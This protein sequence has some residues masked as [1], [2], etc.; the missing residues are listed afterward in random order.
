M[1]KNS[2]MVI[3]EIQSC[4][5]SHIFIDEFHHL[6]PKSS[7]LRENHDMSKDG[8]QNMHKITFIMKECEPKARCLR[9][10]VHAK[11]RWL[12]WEMDLAS[13]VRPIA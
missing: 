4:M 6:L 2:R 3:W 12:R 11:G 1:I 8:C 5:A 10:F 7:S 13:T 9:S